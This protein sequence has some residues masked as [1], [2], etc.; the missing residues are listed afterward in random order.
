M[1]IKKAISL[2]T[3]MTLN[4]KTIQLEGFW[5]EVIGEPEDNFQAMF[6]GP[7]KSGKSTLCLQLCDELARFG[8]VFYNVWE[9][10]KSKKLQDR[11]GNLDIKNLDNIFIQKYKFEEMMDDEFKRR[12][13]KTIVFDSI[14]YMKFTYDEYK[15][16]HQ[17]YPRK[18]LLFVSQVNGKGGAKGGT[19]FGHAVD[20][21]IH[22]K[23]G[24]ARV[25]SR[26]AEPKNIEIF[27]REL[28][29]GEQ[30]PLL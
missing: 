6:Y 22:C 25:D 12:Y 9:E 15:Q 30:I 28:K 5:N 13:Y 29:A 26:F 21:T 10:G 4:F 1:A 27:K 7:Q 20:V 24:M 16:F 3:L 8:K 17:K 11:V 14:Q 19:D 2:K 23:N 18:I